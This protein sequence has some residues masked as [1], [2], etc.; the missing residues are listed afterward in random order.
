MCKAELEKES[1]AYC[2]CLD[3]KYDPEE[4]GD[5]LMRQ[6]WRCSLCGAEFKRHH[7]AETTEKLLN[8]ERAIK[9]RLYEDG[10]PCTHAGCAMHFSH[11]CENCN[12]IATE[13]RAYAPIDPR[14]RTGESNESTKR[15]DESE[16]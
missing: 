3:V 2:A 7:N 4:V 1:Q 12:R 13:G 8:A 11:P 14:R 5:S 9:E 10:E 15:T 16:G 6:R